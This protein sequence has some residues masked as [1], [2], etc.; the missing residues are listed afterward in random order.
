MNEFCARGKTQYVLGAKP[1]VFK[2]RNSVFCKGRDS[3]FSR[4]V[5]QPLERCVNHGAKRGVFQS[6]KSS[7]LHGAKPS[8][9]QGAKLSVLNLPNSVFSKRETQC[10]Q[11]AE[12]SL[13]KALSPR[14]FRGLILVFSKVRYPGVL[15][16]TKPSVL[17]GAQPG[18]CKMGKKR[19]AWYVNHCFQIANPGVL[20]GAKPSDFRCAKPSVTKVRN[21]VVCKV[22]NQVFF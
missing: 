18:Y 5:T 1:I 19:L 14:L 20:Q 8:V 10:L 2:A 6:A 22:R 4:C 12:Q 16:G 3:V 7:P 11:R 21:A 13:T 15:Q 9:L 17:Q